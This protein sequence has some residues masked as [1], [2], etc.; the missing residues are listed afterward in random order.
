MKRINPNPFVVF[1]LQAVLRLGLRA[2]ELN[3]LRREDVRIDALHG[4]HEI[5]VHAPDKTDAFIPVD[6]TFLAALNM[7]EAWSEEARNSAEP[8]TAQTFKDVLLVYPDTY[9]RYS[10]CELKRFNTYYLNS[11]H[12]PYF[13]AKW[14]R[15]MVKG[16]DG[17]ERPLLHADGDPTH[18]FSADYRK[19]RNAFAVHFAERER[20]RVLTAQ[21]MRHKAVHTAERYYLHQTRL[22]HAKKVQIALKTEA[23]FLVLGLKNAL[24]SGITEETLHRARIA[25]AITPHGLCNSALQGQGCS[26]ASDCLECEHLV[27]ITS[28][29]PRFA[30]DRDAYLKMAEDFEAGGDLRAAE[31]ARGRASV[32]QAH[33]IRI[34]EQFNGEIS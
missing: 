11:S 13:Y 24:A 9:S 23:N 20:N 14:F 7:C 18:P 28:R 19:L 32:C 17:N 25:G 4:N 27:V 15:H 3:S 6:E 2:S 10:H 26:R 31:N 8:M 22:D 16:E 34:D 5:Y 21:V 1:A 29:R 30:A 12:L 33:L